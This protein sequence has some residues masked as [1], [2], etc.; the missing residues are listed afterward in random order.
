MR[1]LLTA[2]LGAMLLA[3]PAFAQTS[4]PRPDQ[5]PGAARAGSDPGASRTESES[6]SPGPPIDR[7]PFTPE[8]SQAHRGGG[9]ILEGAPG[10]PAPA[11]QP[12]PPL[13]TPRRP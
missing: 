3:C 9:A 1:T 2:A 13:D 4:P 6:R 10:A 8:A 5:A 7:G 11:P 12:T